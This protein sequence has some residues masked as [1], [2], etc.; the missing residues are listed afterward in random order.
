[1]PNSLAVTGGGLH[2][3]T[4]MRALV[5]VEP[6]GAKPRKRT[7]RKMLGERRPERRESDELSIPPSRTK[8]R[9]RPIAARK[10]LLWAI[11]IDDQTDYSRDFA[12]VRELV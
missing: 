11:V 1:M 7:R 10:L 5:K 3:D 2:F 12:Y 4:F 6:E 8:V 9:D